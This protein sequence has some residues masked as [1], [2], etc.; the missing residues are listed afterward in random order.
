M[1]SV[2]EVVEWT[3]AIRMC[4]AESASVEPDSVSDEIL[5]DEGEDDDEPPPNSGPLSLPTN[6]LKT[7]KALKKK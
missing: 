2:Q 7:S 6:L 1:E 5:S 4:I 3:K